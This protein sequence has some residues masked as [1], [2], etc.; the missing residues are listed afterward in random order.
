MARKRS[1]KTAPPEVVVAQTTAKWGFWGALAGATALVIVAAINVLPLWAGRAQEQ[2]KDDK[3]ST[4]NQAQNQAQSGSGV[5][6]GNNSPVTINVGGSAATEIKKPDVRIGTVRVLPTKFAQEFSRFE[7]H[8]AKAVIDVIL[9]N[10]GTGTAALTEVR[11][12]QVSYES[13]GPQ[14]GSAAELSGKYPLDLENLRKEGAQTIPLAHAIA[15]QAVDRFLVVAADPSPFG[16]SLAQRWKLKAVFAFAGGSEITSDT[17]ELTLPA[18]SDPRKTEVLP[19]TL[20]EEGFT[21]IPTAF[22]EP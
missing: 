19:E 21:V 9:H 12:R 11:F 6:T 10:Q 8:K 5:Q 7:D 13:F 20:A 2:P 1:P 4:T 15:P 17:F 18:R 16:H 3:P 22:S 14:G